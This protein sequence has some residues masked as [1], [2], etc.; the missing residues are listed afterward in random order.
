MPLEPE[1]FEQLV[2][3]STDIVVATA[4][5]GQ[6]IYYNDG[7]KR[8]LGYTQEEILGK[9]VAQL[10]PS[11]DEAKRVMKAMRSLD[12][13]GLGIVDSFQTTYVAKSGERIPVTISGT[14][15]FAETGGED[16]TCARFCA[17]ISSPRWERSRSDSRTRSTTRWR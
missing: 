16:G 8:S 3:R 17:R 12:Y 9:Y 1:R 6:V 15:I 10:Y 5:S 4:K 14:I 11:L 13:G 2:A 7:A